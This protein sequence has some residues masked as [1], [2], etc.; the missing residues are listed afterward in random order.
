[1]LKLQHISL[2]YRCTALDGSSLIAKLI[3]GGASYPIDLHQEAA[4]KGHAP[5]ILNFAAEKCFP[6]ELVPPARDGG[7]DQW[8]RL[9]ADASLLWQ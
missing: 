7:P 5:A 9:G 2:V 4:A 8:Q 1:M 6:G 3:P